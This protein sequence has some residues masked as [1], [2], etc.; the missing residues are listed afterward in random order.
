MAFQD[1]IT[2]VAQEADRRIAEAKASQKERLLT[3]RRE[4]EKRLKEHVGDITA[5]VAQQKAQMQSRALTTASVAQRNAVLAKKRSL[6]DQLYGEVERAIGALPPAKIEPFLRQC[7]AKID[8]AKGEILPARPHA[9]LLKKLVGA[10]WPVGEPVDAAGGF[11][12]VSDRREE[13]FTLE[14]VIQDHIRPPT[15]VGASHALFSA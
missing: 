2:A 11:R 13:D 5:Q 1:I 6:I 3:L 7:L 9:A 8:G 12:F 4:S 10:Q 15:E 14:R